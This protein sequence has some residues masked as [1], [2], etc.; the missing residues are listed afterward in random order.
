M[1]LCSILSSART[2]AAEVKIV[3]GAAIGYAKSLQN[4]QVNDRD[5]RVYMPQV[6]S[7]DNIPD[8]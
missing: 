6:I 5:I 8:T 3:R 1:V 7:L 4:T 2:G